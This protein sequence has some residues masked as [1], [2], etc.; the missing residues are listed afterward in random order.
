MTGRRDSTDTLHFDEDEQRNEKDDLKVVQ[1]FS[2]REQMLVGIHE[3]VGAVKSSTRRVIA[4]GELRDN[5]HWVVI[6]GMV[7][8]ISVFMDG[9]QK[10]P[11]GRRILEKQLSEGQLA[12]DRFLKWHHPSGNA[13]RQL[14]AHYVGDYLRKNDIIPSTDA[15]LA[16]YVE[17]KTQKK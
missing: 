14:R 1:G 10:H 16:A 15:A 5:P 17:R 9:S 4:E 11:G 6:A 2:K 7:F 8:D 3:H 12:E 13:V